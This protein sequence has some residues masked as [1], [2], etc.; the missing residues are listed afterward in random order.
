MGQ[1]STNIAGS[2]SELIFTATSELEKGVLHTVNVNGVKDMA[3]NPMQAFSYAFTTVAE[4]EEISQSTEAEEGWLSAW[5]ELTIGI[6]AIIVS[7]IGWMLLR[8]SRAK[9]RWYLSELERVVHDLGENVTEL[10]QQINRMKKDVAEDYHKGRLDEKQYQLVEKKLEDASSEIRRTEAE[11]VLGSI[12][13]SLA[14]KLEQALAD[15]HIDNE[16]V[17]QM[18]S[19]SSDLDSEQQSDLAS[20]LKRWKDEDE[21]P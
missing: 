9:V 8:R 13:E 16:E 12:P 10:E 21:E 7:L 4:E 19:Q 15:G 5:G 3:G 20:M 1:T 14:A 2:K 18:L 11:E 6:G 17:E